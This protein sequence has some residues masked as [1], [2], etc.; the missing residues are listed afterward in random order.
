MLHNHVNAEGATAIV[1]AV[2]DKPQILTLCGIRPEET[3]RDFSRHGLVVGDAILLAFDLRK[4]SALVQLKYADA[5]PDSY[6][7]Q[8][9]TLLFASYS[10]LV[11]SLYGNSV[12]AEGAKYLSEAL[13]TN[14]SL[15]SLKCA[16]AHHLMTDVIK[17]Q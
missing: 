17:R 8:P 11:H 16:P 4:N 1:D 15:T 5:L 14:Q 2:K 6:C 7:Q 12:S 13:A 10:H 3:E 9:L